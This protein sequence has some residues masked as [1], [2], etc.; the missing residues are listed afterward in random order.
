MKFRDRI[1]VEY[2]ARRAALLIALPIV[3]LL[4]SCSET[5]PGPTQTASPPAVPSSLTILGVPATLSMG[6]SVQLTARATMP[7]G[8]T[9]AVSDGVTWQSS[10]SS[11]AT[12]STSGLLTVKGSGDADVNAIYQSVK[13]SAHVKV[14]TA[15]PA[16]PLFD[17]DGLVHEPDLGDQA[18]VQG[19]RVTIAG[20]AAD[21]QST[22]TDA[23]GR[24]H[25]GR[26]AEAPW[27]GIMLWTSKDGYETKPYKILQLPRDQNPDVTL[28]PAAGDVLFDV[29]GT[30]ACSELPVLDPT[31]PYGARYVGEFV[32]YH[33]GSLVVHSVENP[34]DIGGVMFAMSKVTPPRR[35]PLRTDPVTVL[36][37]GSTIPNHNTGGTI[38]APSFPI[39]AGYRYVFWFDSDSLVC[40]PYSVSLTRP[41]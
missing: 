34:G 15:A 39:A 10:D 25:F 2:M 20:G 41:R 6:Q 5:P 7:D 9:N 1:R 35:R 18:P 37:T 3:V 26:M 38:Q 14:P 21:G 16:V 4:S 13:A 32:A 29:H 24:F 31:N 33:S 27:P 28:T 17:I 30:N 36:V 40:V 22:T 11:V 12:V 23:Q 8:T 19:A